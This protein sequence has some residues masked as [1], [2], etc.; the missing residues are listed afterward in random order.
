MLEAFD[1]LAKRDSIKT[2]VRKKSEFVINLFINELEKSKME[3]DNLR[4]NQDKL[5]IPLHHGH[6]SG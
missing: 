4:K 2:A 3:Y 5:N 1:Y 6:F